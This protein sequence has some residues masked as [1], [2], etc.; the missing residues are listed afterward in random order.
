AGVAVWIVQRIA[1][2]FGVVACMI[3]QH[4]FPL[5]RLGKAVVTRSVLAVLVAGGEH[6]LRGFMPVRR[7]TWVSIEVDPEQSHAVVFI[8]GAGGVADKQPIAVEQHRRTFVDPETAALPV[9]FRFAEHHRIAFE[10]PWVFHFAQIK[11]RVTGDI[12]GFLAPR[13]TS[14]YPDGQRWWHPAQ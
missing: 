6:R 5:R 11:V 2:D 14:V 1:F 10:R 3:N 8:G 4:V 7:V 13:D 9:I 12:R